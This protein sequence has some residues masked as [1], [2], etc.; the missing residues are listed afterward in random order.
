MATSPIDPLEGARFVL[1][2]RVVTMDAHFTVIAS[3]RV[4]VDAGLI[5]DV[6]PASAPAP[7]EFVGA[8]L[9]RTR[10][11]IYPGLIELHNHLSYNVI[12]LWRVPKEFDNRAQW[13]D[14]PEKRRL[15]SQPMQV[16]ASL[17][18]TIPAVVRYVE[19]KCLV[20][21][22]T[23]SQGITLSSAPGIRRHYRGI[24]RNVE[25]TGDPAL[26]QSGTRIPDVTDPAPFLEQ[27]KRS[28]SYLLHLSEG[29]DLKSR[30]HFQR[31]R[32]ADDTWAITDALLGI[33]GTGLQAEDFDVL[34][35]NGGSLVW[36][37]LSNLL[38]YRKTT[39]VA[40]AKAAGVRIALGSDWSPS[41][42]KNLLAELKVAMAYS[43]VSGGLFTARELAEMVTRN[44]ARM[45]KWDGALGSIEAGKRADLL[46]LGG[47]TAD[48][49]DQLVRAKEPDIRLVVINGTPRYGLSSLVAPIGPDVE[50]LRVGGRARVL[51][52]DQATADPVVAKIRLAD[53]QSRL[54][55]ALQRLPELAMG[56]LNP[57][58]AA[59]MLGVADPTGPAK[60]TLEL[61]DEPAERAAQRPLTPLAGDATALA[62]APLNQV[63]TS[64]VL[65]PLTVA[66]DDDYFRRIADQPNLRRRDDVDAVGAQL[67]AIAD[68][69]YGLFG[70]P[71]P[72]VD[73]SGVA[74]GPGASLDATTAEPVPV[75]RLYELP[76]VLALA[77]RKRIA[78][79][80][81]LMFDDVY[82]HLPLKQAAYAV[83][84]LQRLRVL[85]HRLSQMEEGKLGPDLEFH[86]ELQE[87]FTEVRDLHTSYLL[88][89]P[90]R[91]HTAFLP[92]LVEQSFDREG[93]PRYL[94]TKVADEL[95][96][97]K[98]VPGV[99]VLYWNGVA[100]RQALLAQGDRQAGANPEARFARALSALTIRPLVRLLPPDEEWVVVTYC[101][102]DGAVLELRQDWKV[103]A[104]GRSAPPGLLESEALGVAGNL[105]LDI[106]TDAVNVARKEL[107]A[108]E[109]VAAA[110]RAV[111][112]RAPTSVR[113]SD[114]TTM[115]TVFRAKTVET[116]SGK[117]AYVRIF[118]FAVPDAD[119]F[120]AEFVRLLAGLPQDG[121]ILDVRNNAG[122]LIPAAEGLLQVLT[123]RHIEPQRAQFISTPLTL[124]LCRRHAPSPLDRSF[125]LS[126]WVES[127]A[128]SVTTG[129]TYSH[130][131]PI[132][133]D[134]AA[135]R[136]GQRY[137]GSTVLVTDALCYSATD[138]LVAGFRDHEIGPILGVDGNTG[139]GGANVWR[140]GLLQ[141]LMG[142]TPPPDS[143]Y[144]Q[145]PFEQLPE[146]VD[147][148]VAVRRTL[149]TGR[150]AGTPVEDLGIVPDEIYRM[151]ERDLLES[152]ADLIERAAALVAAR[153][154]YQLAAS[155]ID[156]SATRLKVIV[157]TRAL[158]RLDVL[159]DS[160]PEGSFD[161]KDGARTLT[162]PLHR[163]QR[164]ARM[165]LV[166][167][168]AGAVAARRIEALG[169]GQR[170]EG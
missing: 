113:G 9:L 17:A 152:N 29:K 162:L 23:T 25:Q 131:H 135:N 163:G 93:R 126:P 145:N 88:P 21:G 48:P 14:H 151:T 104:A 125:D 140:H 41:G 42:S 108:R 149:R 44:P 144:P 69:M 150:A 154:K 106:Q 62:S 136:T 81:R 78:R 94:V 71:P 39:D 22:V 10:G 121:L 56:L 73:P 72:V 146:G 117:L 83:D 141:R 47:T 142:V 27:L 128:Q 167:Y 67:E 109:A 2:G 8:K 37:P 74:F 1:D 26:P 50:P 68:A 166:G 86:R 102:R 155:D 18:D 84:P 40:R 118:T 159:V 148:T 32:I 114:D 105:G 87:I 7:A 30:E 75:R 4:Y 16:L 3:G 156:V 28:K 98:F 89:S 157:S 158:D 132:T 12:P 59:A 57:L 51:E 61:D 13:Q 60:W 76:S 58:R 79:Q 52:F 65:D 82:A 116:R 20:A 19:A 5:R 45:L 134:E 123:P 137:H 100:I 92:F 161:V 127:L 46:V 122:G 43:E 96:H 15:V 129:A 31:L 153:P 143:A 101:A 91:E 38:L 139:A 33:H 35:A 160:R 103:W 165:E 112:T 55:D 120:V 11:T 90:Y 170:G 168:A 24:V 164:P 169:S 138:M 77:D 66:D 133:P 36:S 53:A 110:R 6:R 107:Y 124:E 111:R 54:A 147:M 130:G 63:L 64:I 119:A 95:R 70:V 34:A 115:P 97:P 85:E 80:A 99:E 49:Y